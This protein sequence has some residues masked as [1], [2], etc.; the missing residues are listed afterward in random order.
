[1]P[2]DI[3][4]MM[5]RKLVRI[6]ICE[7]GGLVGTPEITSKPTL[8]RPQFFKAI[9]DFPFRNIY[10]LLLMY[11]SGILIVH[12]VE[13]PVL[14]YRNIAIGNTSEKVMQLANSEFPQ[15]KLLPR[16]YSFDMLSI[17]AGDDQD[18]VDSSCAFAATSNR[19]KNCLSV[20]FLF[21]SETRGSLLNSIF[22]EQSFNPP[23][24][25]DAV[26]AK[27]ISSYGKPK[28][29]NSDVVPASHMSPE[30]KLTVLLWGGMKA[31][32]NSYR[33]S[34]FPYED[35]EII[36]GKYISVVMYSQ[37]RMINGY[38]LRIVDSDSVNESSADTMSEL[39]RLKTI[40]RSKSEAS[41]KF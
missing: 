26:V 19:Q 14:H 20:R 10:F 27:L 7:A 22:V 6:E 18:M 33:P 12:A 9:Y 28:F 23:I 29:K 21:S 25:R 35:R 38:S 2:D 16:K 15:I 11:L 17:L 36:G 30:S 1:V 34:V 3:L 39:E 41:V 37:G 13:P 8:L 5:T 32:K 40:R 4:G 31:P 24:D